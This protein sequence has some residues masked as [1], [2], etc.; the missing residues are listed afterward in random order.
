MTEEQYRQ[1]AADLWSRAEAL[2]MSLDETHY[3]KE[4]A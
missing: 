1:A 2:G 4:E 3:G